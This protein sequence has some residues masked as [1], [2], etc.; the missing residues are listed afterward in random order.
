[1]TAYEVSLGRTSICYENVRDRATKVARRWLFPL[2][3]SVEM[4]SRTNKVQIALSDFE[5][6]LLYA[7]IAITKTGKPRRAL[8]HAIRRS[9]QAEGIQSIVRQRIM[10]A[11]EK[12]DAETRMRYYNELSKAAWLA[13]DNAS[14]RFGGPAVDDTYFPNLPE[15]DGIEL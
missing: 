11:A 6:Q 13:V 4:P 15:T 2:C 5:Y 10:M 1:M 14:K 12:L 7:F 8:M 3:G 9:I